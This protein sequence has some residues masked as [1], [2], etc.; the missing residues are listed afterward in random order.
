MKWIR[1]N[2]EDLYPE[3]PKK[4]VTMSRK[5]MD[6]LEKI[7]RSSARKRSRFC[8]HS[9]VDSDVHEMMICHPKGTYVSPHK[10]V[11]KDESFHL[12]SG[13][14]D[15]LLFDDQ[16]NIKD[17]LHMGNYKSGEPFYYRIPADIFH[18]QIFKQ[19]TIFHEVT[20]GPFNK[21]DTIAADWAPDEKDAMLVENYVRK[22]K[23]DINI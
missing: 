18:T 2:E 22:M 20:K 15:L 11:G 7:A 13:E 12:I 14:I 23:E 1:E 8:A 21:N 6:C 3:Q 9:S 16:G 5:N 19:D 10:H 17:V 4:L